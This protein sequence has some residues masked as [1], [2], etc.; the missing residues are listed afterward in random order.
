MPSAPFWSLHSICPHSLS[1]YM[2]KMTAC[3]LG[4]TEWVILRVFWFFV[5]Y[6]FTCFLKSC[7]IMF[8]LVWIHKVHSPESLSTNLPSNTLTLPLSLLPSGDWPNPPS[9]SSLSSALITWSSTS[10]QTTS[11]WACG[12]ASSCVWAPSRYSVCYQHN[13][14]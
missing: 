1:L 11:T 10:S 9:S 6:S 3:R 2:E 8:L 4:M 13:T 12:F 5:Y 14:A 7:L